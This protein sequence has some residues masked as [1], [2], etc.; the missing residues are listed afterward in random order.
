MPCRTCDKVVSA[1]PRVGALAALLAAF[2]FHPAFAQDSE[3]VTVDVGQCTS[4]ESADARLACFGAQVDA[5]L[6]E[7]PPSEVDERSAVTED[8]D[9]DRAAPRSDERSRRA[10]EQTERTAKR[11]LRA[12][13]R[14]EEALEDAGEGEYSGVI[15][16]I[17][18]RLPNA[19]V[20][21]LDNGQ[22]WQQTEPKQYP[23]RPGLEVRIYP[24]GWGNYYRLNGLGTGTHIQVRRVR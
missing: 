9:A 15:V 6:E 11:R 13:S 21:T 16:A 17:R 1:R 2:A 19:Y 5:A 23:L 22:V 24:T 7:R 20:I 10:E 4:L 14:S 18:E 8:A 12:H 3:T